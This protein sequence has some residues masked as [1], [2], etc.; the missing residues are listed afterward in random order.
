MG[1]CLQVVKF[2]CGP[3]TVQDQ[4]VP[5]CANAI[6]LAHAIGIKRIKAGL[7]GMIHPA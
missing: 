6:V 5:Y 1:V 3:V 4:L 7:P 2:A